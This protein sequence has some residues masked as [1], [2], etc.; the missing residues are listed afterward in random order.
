MSDRVLLFSR[1][2]LGDLLEE[3]KVQLLE[4][5]DSVEESRV[6]SSATEDVIGKHHQVPGPTPLKLVEGEILTDRQDVELEPQRFGT[7]VR[8]M[9]R[10]PKR[11]ATIVTFHVPFEGDPSL[12]NYRPTTFT[13]SPPV[14]RIEDA[15]LILEYEIAGRDPS[16]VRR[17][18]D[19]DLAEIKQWL[20]WIERDVSQSREVTRPKALERLE[21]RRKRI[22][23]GE[24]VL[25]G[26]GFP[27]RR[28]A[29][30]PQ[31]YRVPEIR[32]KIEAT[33]ASEQL[34]IPHRDPIEPTLDET[35]YEHIL[36]VMNN[37][38]AVMER[39]PK[40]FRD[41]REEDL[42]QHFLVQLNGQY[43]GQASGETFNFEGKTDILIRW[44]G[45]NL[46]IAE[47]KFWQGKSS[48]QE[49]LDQLLR[50][51]TWKDTKTAVLLFNRGRHLSDVLAQIPALA[52]EH[53]NYTRDLPFGSE[54][55]FRFCLHHRDDPKREIVVTVLVFEIP[56]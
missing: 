27:L 15:E 25:S 51:T 9:G 40:T 11:V 29:E 47:C 12:W 38:V 14:A 23:D 6:I 22:L 43:E 44:Q 8:S 52:R 16:E 55:G 20:G 30:S 10:I 48:L 33:N 54:T 1:R 28:R 7:L 37:M 34:S 13:T 2:S 21:N 49:A 41:M 24:S 32:R 53:A 3:C 56:S 35:E 19:R 36:S 50:Y 5:I 4:S 26:L 39:S 45:R 46:F 18:F 17:E 42:R 31:T